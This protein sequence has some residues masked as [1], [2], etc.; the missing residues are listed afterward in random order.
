MM[1]NLEDWKN[2][3]PIIRTNLA[4]YLN[5][6][7]DEIAEDFAKSICV[8]KKTIQRVASGKI[9][10][11]YEVGIDKIADMANALNLTYD[12]L[13]ERNFKKIIKYRISSNDCMWKM[14]IALIAM[15]VFAVKFA[16]S[17][18]YVSAAIVLAAAVEAAC[19]VSNIYGIQM[20]VSFFQKFRYV[21]IT[22][23]LVSV[24]LFT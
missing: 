7:G 20:D 22:L 8:T 13:I 4:M 15:I 12:D 17:F 11:G 9:G 10:L 24:L 23:A 6:H 2:N 18:S 21:S 19:N 3:E 16:V 1:K 5:E 14:I